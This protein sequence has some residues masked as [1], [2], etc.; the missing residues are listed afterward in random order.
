MS[1][2]WVLY[3]QPRCPY[4][5]WSCEPG[6]ECVCLTAMTETTDHAADRRAWIDGLHRSN[7]ILLMSPCC[8]NMEQS[9][10][11]ARHLRVASVWWTHGLGTDVGIVDK[12]CHSLARTPSLVLV[13][14][15]HGYVRLASGIK[16]YLPALLLVPGLM[17]TSVRS[18]LNQPSPLAAF[19]S[20]GR[21]PVLPLRAYVLYSFSVSCCALHWR[22]S[23][24]NCWI[25][26]GKNT[27]S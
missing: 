16:L 10:E 4:C 9:H 23:C 5:E 8:S 18:T 15:V 6:Y 12:K 13:L 1:S 22:F 2:L 20:I 11:P 25:S 21:N 27:R 17:R 14:D 3:W 7:G 26:A 19:V 24:W